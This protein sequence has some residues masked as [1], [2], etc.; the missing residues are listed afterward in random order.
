MNNPAPAWRVPAIA[1]GLAAALVLTAAAQRS[2]DAPRAVAIIDSRSVTW[3]DLGPLLAE[4][5]GGQVLD[6]V[7]LVDAATKRAAAAGITLTPDMVQAERRLFI[8]SLANTGV[9]TDPDRAERLLAE[10][11]RSRGLGEKRFQSLLERSALLRAIVRK[12]GDVTVTD[13]DIQQAYRIRYGPQRQARVIVTTSE[14]EAQAALN[15]VKTNGEPFSDVAVEISTD[16]SRTRGGLLGW[17]RTDD[18]G[19]P[20]A[21]RVAIESLAAGEIAGPVALESGYAVVKV[22][23]IR[24]QAQPSIESVRDSLRREVESVRER[25]AIERLAV[26]LLEETRPRVTVFDR[27]LDTAWQPR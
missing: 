19:F 10:V 23:E 6:E 17:V 16:A 5:A 4:A 7:I 27:S 11:R 2:A 15:R 25:A 18:P 24:E 22:E 12:A 13:D 21:L 20:V 3:D 1:L 9:S 8:D 26:T 14:R